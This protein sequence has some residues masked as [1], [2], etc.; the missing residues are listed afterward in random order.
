MAGLA[1][2]SAI[3]PV[4]RG[5][6]G[7]GCEGLMKGVGSHSGCAEVGSIFASNHHGRT[8][9]GLARSWP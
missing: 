7:Y 3:A 4:K 6:C 2:P 8:L 1:A 9:L 5:A